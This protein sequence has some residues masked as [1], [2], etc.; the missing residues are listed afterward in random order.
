L[1][2]SGLP[3]SLLVDHPFTV[4]SIDE[5]ETGIQVM[6]EVGI[7]KCMD[8]KCSSE[9]IS[10]QMAPFLLSE[11]RDLTDR[12]SITYL[13]SELDRVIAEAKEYVRENNT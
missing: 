12:A 9:H 7:A 11:F 2:V 1:S 8:K 5:F 3:E 13:N 10:W 6:N 4:M